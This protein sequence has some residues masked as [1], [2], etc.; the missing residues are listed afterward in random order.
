MEAHFLYPFIYQGAFRPLVRLSNV[1]NNA[2]VN[3]GVEVVVWT[4]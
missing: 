3:M 2:A 4:P 1:V